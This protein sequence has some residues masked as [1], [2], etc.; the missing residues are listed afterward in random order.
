MV[1][2]VRVVRWPNI[3]HLVDAAAFVAALKGPSAGDLYIVKQPYRI[4]Y[5]G[6][7]GLG[8]VEGRTGAGI[9]VLGSV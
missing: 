2:M 5:G 6:L 7:L 4:R 3:F 1:R 9:G 8:M